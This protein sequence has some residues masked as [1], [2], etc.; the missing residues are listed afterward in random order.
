[1]EIKASVSYPLSASAKVDGPAWR[2]PAPKTIGTTFR[3]GSTSRVVAI[4]AACLI[5]GI[6]IVGFVVLS[7][8]IG[9]QNQPGLGPDR[10][11]PPM[12]AASTPSLPPP[13]APPETPQ[14]GSPPGPAW[15]VESGGAAL[16]LARAAE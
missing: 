7:L 1:V 13:V 6:V 2:A 16:V 4:A 9:A 14:P 10:P 3:T 15:N 11:P 8:G 12:P 5:E